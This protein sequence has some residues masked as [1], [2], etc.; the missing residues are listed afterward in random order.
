MSFA[1]RLFVAPPTEGGEQPQAKAG[2]SAVT[3]GDV[4]DAFCETR[5]TL[6]TTDQITQKR[7]SNERRYLLKFKATF[8][9]LTEC[10]DPR[11]VIAR[12]LK[13]N[14]QWASPDSKRDAVN[15][16]C[17]AFEWASEPDGANLIARP[18]FRR[19]KVSVGLPPPVPR[20]PVYIRQLLAVFRA[21]RRRG[22]KK[23]R[24]CFR[25][26]LH[27]MF[28][29]G[30]RPCE[31]RRVCWEHLSWDNGVIRLPAELSKTGKKTGEARLIVLSDRMFR[32]IR[33]NWERRGRP[34]AG[35]IFVNSRGLPMGAVGFADYFR[36][37]ADAA[38]L[39]KDCTSA[40]L[41][42]GFAIRKIDEGNSNKRVADLMGHTSTAMVDRVYDRHVREAELIRTMRGK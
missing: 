20:Q 25:F 4:I 17:A 15:T 11:G 13:A 26:A 32:L 34:T 39:P 40:G 41:R 2:E 8:G 29:S 10:A 42:H 7:W 24:D 31:M 9:E 3:F 38:K 23:A 36:V 14:P 30:S 5:E 22:Q 18:Y 35:P 19:R 6:A 1:G 37:V 16:I 21:A 12:W 28:E 27:F 33:V